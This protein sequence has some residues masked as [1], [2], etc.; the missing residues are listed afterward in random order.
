MDNIMAT[1]KNETSHFTNKLLAQIVGR[2]IP[3]KFLNVFAFGLTFSWGC[4][5]SFPS[6][7]SFNL[8]IELDNIHN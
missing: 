3:H 8:Q 6:F 1:L 7:M 5:K 2:I 4:V